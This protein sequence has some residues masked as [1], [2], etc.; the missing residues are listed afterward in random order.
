MITGLRKLANIYPNML[1]AYN[2]T[3]LKEDFE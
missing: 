3:D 2:L 1:Q